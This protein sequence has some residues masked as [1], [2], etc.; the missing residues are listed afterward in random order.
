MT[1]DPAPAL[2]LVEDNSWDADLAVRTLTR[3]GLADDYRLLRDG[4]E[5]LDALFDAVKGGD[6]PQLILLDLKLPHTSGLQVLQWIRANPRTS[7]LPVAILTGTD[8]DR[9]IVE[10]YKLGVSA[11]FTKPLDAKEL[12]TLLTN[13]GIPHR[14]PT[15]AG[16]ATPA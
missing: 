5:A 12:S 13:L 8:N 4:K 14:A 7:G 9:D 15:N 10:I 1:D 6:F 2:F 3:L 16:R 11:Y